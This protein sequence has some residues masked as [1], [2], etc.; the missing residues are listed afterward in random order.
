MS[1]LCV[2]GCEK[3][4]APP[5]PDQQQRRVELRRKIQATLGEQYDEPVPAATPTQL[6]RGIELYAQ[7]CSPCHGSQGDGKVAHP[8]GL[9]QQPSD[10]TDPREAELFS[11]QG[12]LYVIRKGVEGTAMMGWE[13]VL[14][15]SDIM[16]LYLFV[17]SLQKK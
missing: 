9:L 15:E 6:K 2:C 7:L 1:V 16:A 14:P 11:E 13:E 8:G 17:R 10:F 5:P 12:R 4:A 3:K